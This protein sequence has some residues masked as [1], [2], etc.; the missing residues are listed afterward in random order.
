[1]L[2]ILGFQALAK[3]NLPGT[4][5][6]HC[7]DRVPT[8]HARCFSKSTVQPSRVFLI[9]GKR[10]VYQFQSPPFLKR[11]CN[12][13]T[14]WPVRMNLPFFCSRSIRTGGAP[15]SGQ[16]NL[17]NVFRPVLARKSIFPVICGGKELLRLRSLLEAVAVTLA[18][19][20][21]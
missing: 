13:G 19:P 20:L 17:K 8:F 10:N 15:E 7:L 6:R 14:K 11:S 16:K 3:A 1:M 18:F 12:G 9:Q 21:P 5:G 4:L 2:Q